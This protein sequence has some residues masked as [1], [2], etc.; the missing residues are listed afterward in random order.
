[1]NTI[2]LEHTVLIIGK[3]CSLISR[4][5]SRLFTVMYCYVLYYT[6]LQCTVLCVK[7]LYPIHMEFFSGRMTEKP[8]KEDG[9]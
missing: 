6:V 7:S 9:K 4:V 3:E 8:D 2:L 1:M 5:E